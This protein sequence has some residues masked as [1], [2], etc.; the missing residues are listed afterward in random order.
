MLARNSFGVWIVPS[1]D[2][3]PV[4]ALAVLDETERRRGARFIRAAD[5]ALFVTAHAALRYL[6]AAVT[7]L[8][9]GHIRLSTTSSGKPM[10]SPIHARHGVE[11]NI[12]HS[13]GL[14][15]I[16]LSRCGA[17]GVDIERRRPFPED[18]SITAKLF[19][20]TVARRLAECDSHE[21]HIIFLR[22]WT[23]GEAY[24]KA[25]GLGIAG[26]E[27]PLPI[28]LAADGMPVFNHETDARLRWSL[29]TMMLPDDYVGSVVVKDAKLDERSYLPATT[30]LAAL[31]Q[32][33]TSFGTVQI[34]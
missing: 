12:S 17:I 24:L 14:A 8:R 7:D 16:A 15:A 27:Q 1:T 4:E 10:L 29:L 18:A 5:R 21:R 22:L 32:R 31:S 25:T 13:D 9:P 20:E 26:T 33:S 3:A 28:S 23:T 19:G 11:F 6:L 34:D 2:S 30:T